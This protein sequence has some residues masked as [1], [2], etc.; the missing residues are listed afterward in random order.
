MRRLGSTF[1]TVWL[2]T[3]VPSFML[4]GLMVRW[5]EHG[6]R[7]FEAVW[8]WLAD[9]LAFPV[10]F[11]PLTNWSWRALET[12]AAIPATSGFLILV[13][14]WALMLTTP[15]IFVAG[16]WVLIFQRIGGRPSSASYTNASVPNPSPSSSL[17]SP[18]RALYLI[19]LPLAFLWLLAKRLAAWRSLWVG[20]AVTSIVFALVAGY[21]AFMFGR[22]SYWDRD[23]VLYVLGRAMWWGYL[24]RLHIPQLFQDRWLESMRIIHQNAEVLDFDEWPDYMGSWYRHA[25]F[26][27]VVWLTAARHALPVGAI[28]LGYSL[29]RRL[30]WVKEF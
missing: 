6:A 25:E 28:Y 17:S 27:T 16:W 15:V 5:S 2:I 4:W 30:P 13:A 19:T 7:R 12:S 26:R 9:L 8:R 29:V 20:I 3:F 10:L 23:D 14:I 22:S 21:L 11:S 1:V 18:S 24:D